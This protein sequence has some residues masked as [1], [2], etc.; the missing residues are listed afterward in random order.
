MARMVL[1]A[2]LAAQPVYALFGKRGIDLT[3]Y[4]GPDT[5]SLNDMGY[6]VHNGPHTTLPPTLR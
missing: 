3:S 6:Y 1:R 2:S 5:K 4:P